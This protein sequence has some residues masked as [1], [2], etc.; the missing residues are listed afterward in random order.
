MEK[1]NPKS[2]S[3]ININNDEENGQRRHRDPYGDD[4]RT[5]RHKDP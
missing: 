1:D 5:R 3:I 2:K 4:N